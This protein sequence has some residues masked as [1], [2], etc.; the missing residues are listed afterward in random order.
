MKKYITWH[1][2]TK[3]NLNPANWKSTKYLI[4]G[5]FEW[6]DHCG[7]IS[8]R[9]KTLPS[10]VLEAHRNKR[11]LLIWWEKPGPLED[12]LLPP[13]GG[14][15]WRVQ[16]WLKELLY[17]E[18]G[19]KARSSVAYDFENGKRLLMGGDHKV[20]V[21]FRIQTPTAGEP[22]FHDEQTKD[23]LFSGSK[24]GASTYQQ[25]FHKLFRAFFTPVPR[26]A[27][28]LSG[29]MEQH[30]LV[31]GQYVA[32]HLRAM[33]GNR[34]HRD[35]EEIVKLAVLGVN[36]ASNLLPGAPIYFASDTSLAVDAAM[37]YST[38][39]GLPVVSFEFDAGDPIHLD[40]DDDWKTR[41]AS[42][43]DSTFADLYML[44][45]SRCVAYSNGGYGTFG[46]LLSY[47]SECKLRFFEK[48]S[49]VVKCMWM[50]AN[51]TKLKLA[52]PSTT[53]LF[54]HEQTLP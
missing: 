34:E 16:P 40:K 41:N 9:L 8:D 26:V 33:Y 49:E 24:G 21:V 43:Y 39:H 46:S 50:S 35:V 6:D 11:L 51:S 4:M 20:A 19:P 52:I 12:Y 17:Q 7:G 47:D 23:S 48:R 54:N 15:D 32:A 3:S 29:K 27:S 31:P 13:R 44:A 10:V 18:L 45:Q 14:V 30:G 36:C 38:M 2:K 22:F 25:V 1:Q 37:S 42:A 53:V 5:C 28:L